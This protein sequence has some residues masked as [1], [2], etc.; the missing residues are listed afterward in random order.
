MRKALQLSVCLLLATQICFAQDDYRSP[1]KGS[2]LGFGFDGVD[3]PSLGKPKN[4]SLRNTDYGMSL[5]FMKG[6][7]KRI[8]WSIRYNGLFSDYVKDP[9]ANTSGF[10]SEFEAALH[11]RVLT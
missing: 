10:I 9:D 8:D 3:F 5:Y 2:L 7:T 4:A 1:K 6:L 11:G